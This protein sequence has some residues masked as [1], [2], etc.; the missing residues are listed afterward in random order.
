[1]RRI[2]SLLLALEMG[3]DPPEKAQ[4]RMLPETRNCG[5][6]NLSHLDRGQTSDPQNHKVVTVLH[7][8][9]NS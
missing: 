3:E 7:T 5:H 4:K 2:H 1:M 9:V 8:W 6:L